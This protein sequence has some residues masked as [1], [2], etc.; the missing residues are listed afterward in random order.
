MI[1]YDV[2]D[3]LFIMNTWWYTMRW[4]VYLDVDKYGDVGFIPNFDVRWWCFVVSCLWCRVVESHTLHWRRG[5][6]CQATRAFMPKRR[7]DFMPN[8]PNY[9]QSDGYHMHNIVVSHRVGYVYVWVFWHWV[10]F[11]GLWW[12]A[13][14]YDTLFCDDFCVE[15]KVNMMR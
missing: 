6:L 1:K 8:V 4:Y 5:L 9:G 15:H 2:C 3:G 14:I 12:I 13:M 11:H 10:L 7:W